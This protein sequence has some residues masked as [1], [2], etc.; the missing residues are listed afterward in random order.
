MAY[1][2]ALSYLNQYPSE[3][4]GP[5]TFACD[6]T[7]RN[8]QFDSRLQ[9][10][11]VPVSEEEQTIFDLLNN[12]NFTLEIDFVNTVASCTTLSISEVTDS[13]TT[14]LQLLSCSDTNGTLS[15]KVFLPQHDIKIVATVNGIE[16]VG[17][18][19][20][21]LS[22]PGQENGL[23]TLKELNFLQTFYSSW[24]GTVA[25]APSISMTLTKVGCFFRIYIH[26]FLVGVVEIY[27]SQEISTFYS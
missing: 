10:L 5:S 7:I 27:C 24:P 16:L 22:G 26:I 19:R 25:Q 8:A 15:A 14:S 4:V 20:L 12:Q 17:G 13:A 2:F 11:A 6:S 18:I 23:Q 9:A 1:A 3:E 21:G